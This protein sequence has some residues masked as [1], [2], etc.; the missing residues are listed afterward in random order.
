[1]TK[2]NAQTATKTRAAKTVAK[3]PAKAA[4]KKVHP[5]HD[6]DRIKSSKSASPRDQENHV[7]TSFGGDSFTF[8]TALWQGDIR[9]L[10]APGA[11]YKAAVTAIEKAKS[12]KP[13]LA[14]GV[15]SRDAPQAA[16][17]VADQRGKAK[18]A[19]KADA[20][21]V[22]GKAK[23]DTKAAAPKGDRK[24]KVVVKLADISLR[25][26]TWTKVM[27]ETALANASTEAANAALKKDRKFGDRKIDWKWLSDVR[28]YIKF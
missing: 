8:P 21:Q 7:I 27:V 1:M 22:K 17:A 14:R 24:Y 2:T 5:A 20:V 6:M 25:P 23:A 26:D 19:N 3:A 13:Q 4:D 12:S 18:P 10:C 15:T 9:N 28:G 11:S 16:K